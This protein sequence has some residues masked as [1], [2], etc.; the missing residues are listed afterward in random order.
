MNTRL[1]MILLT[2]LLA[3]VAPLD[4]SAREGLGSWATGN[5]TVAQEGVSLAVS[6]S[7]MGGRDTAT[8]Q[9]DLRDST[10]IPDQDVDGTGEATLVGSPDGVKL[11]AAVNCL[12]VD[13]ETAIVGGEVT[14]SSVERYVGKQVLLFVEDSGKS[15]G[16]FSW[17]LYEAQKYVFCGTFPWGA[18]T[19]EEVAGGSLQVQE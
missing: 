2:L 4:V 13:G 19:P 18:Y 15:K 11:Q 8:G 7:A 16:R 12:A 6:F 10:P 14:H 5:V 17:G 1:W 9:I 3:G